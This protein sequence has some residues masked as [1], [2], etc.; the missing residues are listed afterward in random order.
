M[1][2]NSTFSDSRPANDGRSFGAFRGWMHWAIPGQ[3]HVSRA[4]SVLIRSSV[5]A[6]HGYRHRSCFHHQPSCWYLVCCIYE[7]AWRGLPDIVLVRIMRILPQTIW[8]ALH[9]TSRRDALVSTSL[10]V[11]AM[12]GCCSQFCQSDGPVSFCSMSF[13]KSGKGFWSFEKRFVRRKSYRT[14]CSCN[15]PLVES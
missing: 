14:L 8:S 9:N 13:G 10:G 12:A 11:G 6:G 4:L 5:E 3:S 1:R 7:P 2:R 15:Y